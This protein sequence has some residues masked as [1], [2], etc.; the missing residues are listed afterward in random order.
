[1][2][3]VY[4][5][6]DDIVCIEHVEGDS[7]EVD[8]FRKDVLLNFDDGTIARVGY[9]KAGYGI[10]KIEI[11]QEGSAYYDLTPCHDEDA[12][13]YSDVLEIDAELERYS[14]VDRK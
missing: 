14:V 13:V 10:W 12:P 5:Y 6:S 2:A 3:K 11:E 4:G 1:M 7:T 8:C 9:G